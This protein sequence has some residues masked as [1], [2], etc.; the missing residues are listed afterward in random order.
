MSNKARDSKD[1]YG[2]YCTSSRAANWRSGNNRTKRKLLPLAWHQFKTRHKTTRLLFCYMIC[3]FNISGYSTLNEVRMIMR[4]S[5]K[6]W[7]SPLLMYNIGIHLYALRGTTKSSAV[8]NNETASV[9]M[10]CTYDVLFLTCSQTLR[11]D[12]Q[13]TYNVILRRVRAAIVPWKSNEYYIFQACVCSRN[14]PAC[15][16]YA[17]HF[18]VICRLPVSTIFFP[19]YHI[20]STIL[21]G[22]KDIEH[23]MC[24]DFLYDLC[25]KY[26]SF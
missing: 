7:S 22:K 21:G 9:L 26:L 24:F 15:K 13:Y 6:K 1:E 17:P 20:N 14:Y 19:R 8:R 23:E 2:V 10:A 4:G 11:Q 18:I 3:C 5:D 12:R 25:L 16:A